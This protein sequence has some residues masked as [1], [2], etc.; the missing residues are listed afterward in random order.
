MPGSGDVLDFAWSPDGQRIG[1]RADLQTDD[2]YDLFVVDRS[3]SAAPVPVG[4][5]G[6]AA[7][8]TLPAAW[9][10]LGRH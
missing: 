9:S 3:G 8:S 10:A 7:A 2:Q 4:V 1:F 6:V 5:G